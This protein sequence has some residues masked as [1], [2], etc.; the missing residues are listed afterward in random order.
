VT[1][2]TI[3]VRE[4]RPFAASKVNR[5]AGYIDGVLICGTT[6]RNGRDY[7]AAVLK[8]DY[9]KYEGAAVNCDHRA[10]ATVERRVG[11]FTNV[12]PGTDGKPRGRLHLLKSHPMAER[13]YEAAERNPSLFGMSHVAVCGT[14]RVNG[15]ETVESINKVVSID[16]VADPATT[17]GLY[18]STMKRIREAGEVFAADSTVMKVTAEKLRGLVD[19]LEGGQC[20]LDEFETWVHELIADTRK[21]A[22]VG[23]GVPGAEGLIPTDG[24]AFAEALKRPGWW[25]PDRVDGKA[26]AEWLKSSGTRTFA[27]YT[28]PPKAGGVPATGKA[29]ADWVEGRPSEADVRRFIASVTGN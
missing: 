20:S 1:T 29:F 23:K 26:Y 27:E 11:W 3:T 2:Q 16:L 6:S 12:Q 4:D 15:R 19:M 13:V 22:G 7:P 21:A 10:E 14:T 18:E 24:K 9:A 8:R 5:Q 28:A 25:Q 17:T